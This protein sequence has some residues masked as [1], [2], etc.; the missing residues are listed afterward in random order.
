MAKGFANF[1]PKRRST[2][3][4][5]TEKAVEAAAE[6]EYVRLNLEVPKSLR[7]W[8]QKHAIDTDQTM[9]ELGTH[10]LQTYRERMN[11]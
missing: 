11:G 2:H 3:S 9:R 8:L 4:A 1:D 7:A 5:A 6:E 10:I